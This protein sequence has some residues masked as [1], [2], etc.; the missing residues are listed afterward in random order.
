MRFLGPQLAKR[1]CHLGQ[2]E[3]V[4]AYLIAGADGFQ[5]GWQDPLISGAISARLAKGT[6]TAKGGP[7]TNPDDDT[8]EST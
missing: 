5:C 3:K 2:G 7:C 4:C 1:K 8:S 6:M